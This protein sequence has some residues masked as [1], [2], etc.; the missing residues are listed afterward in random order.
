MC[1]LLFTFEWLWRNKST[2][3]E[4]PLFRD[5]ARWFQIICNRIS[6]FFFISLTDSWLSSFYNLL[7]SKTSRA[8]STTASTSLSTS[9]VV[10]PACK[11]TLTRSLPLGTVGQVIGLA[12]MPRAKRWADN[13]RG[14][15]VRMGMI[16]EGSFCWHGM[17]MSEDGMLD[18][19]RDDV[20]EW[21]NWVESRKRRFESCEDIRLVYREW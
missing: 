20:S 13:R 5:G 2:V 17:V 9:R 16:G 4:W 12:S 1:S 11:H 6:N 8:H 21:V 7:L 15:G 10:C 3:W 19:S 18:R 14:W